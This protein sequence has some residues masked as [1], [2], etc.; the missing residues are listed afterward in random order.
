MKVRTVLLDCDSVILDCSSAVHAAAEQILGCSIR[1]PSTW[2]HFEFDE[3]MSL[4]P[5]EA[6]YFYREI[7]LH[8]TLGYDIELYPGAKEF[9]LELSKTRDIVFVTAHWRG[10]EHWVTA[11]DKL[12]HE[13]F[14]GF[15]VVYTHAKYRV[16][17]DVLLDDK[18]ENI[19]MNPARGW[20]FDQP[21]NRTRRDLRRVCS[22]S[23]AL[24][25]L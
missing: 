16:V 5:Q 9:V 10:I 24:E 8:P 6:E 22:Y 15:D 4:T 21:W 1:H 7:Q 13:N 17:G 3:A 25:V 23:E 20:L 12:L 19:D 2:Q 11:R 14:P 18:P